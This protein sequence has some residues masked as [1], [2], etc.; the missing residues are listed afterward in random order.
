M[1]RGLYYYLP[2]EAPVTP[3]RLAE[4]G[5]SYALGA[6][7]H[8]QAGM[9]PGPDGGRGKVFCLP[10]AGQTGPDLQQA[11]KASWAKIPGATAWVGFD[12]SAP[13]G[14]DELARDRVFEGYWVDLADGRRWLVPV[15][16]ELRGSTVLPRG[17]RWD[18]SA[19]SD[20]EVLPR[21]REIFA[22]ACKAWE[23]ML[24]AAD[25][26]GAGEISVDTDLAAQALALNYRV[27]PAEISHLGLFDT[28]SEVEVVRALLDLPVLEAL[29]KKEASDTG[30]GPPGGA[31]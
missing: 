17:R 4:A 30:G 2:G 19:W 27:G 15:V 28:R 20:G 25:G 1:S 10:G 3:A 5:I 11:A 23:T 9:S 7:G 12:P 29:K 14:P 13:P 21:Y 8:P 18:G 16:R 26:G 6:G 24:A 31:A 22:A